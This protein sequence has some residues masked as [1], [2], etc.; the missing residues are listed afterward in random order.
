MT[1]NS[2]HAARWSAASEAYNCRSLPRQVLQGRLDPR[3]AYVLGDA[4][5]IGAM[6]H[7][8]T[9]F[10]RRVDGF[11]LCTFAQGQGSSAFG[12]RLGVRNR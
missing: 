8:H 5:A 3:T 11:N 10:C 1:L 2:V 6:A 4:L 7:N 12:D 9:L